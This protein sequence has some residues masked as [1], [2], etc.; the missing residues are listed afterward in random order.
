MIRTLFLFGTRP[1]AIKLAPLILE[2]R[3]R[4]ERFR[5]R[6]CVTAQHRFLLD[7]VLQTFRIVPDTDLDLMTEGQQLEDLTA[8]ALKG[9]SEVVKAEAP[10]LVLVQ[11]DTT[12]TM[13]GALAAFYQKVPVGHVEAG[14]RTDNRY[15]PFPEEVNRRITTV[16]SSLHFAPTERARDNLLRE[17]VAAAD[18]FVTG[19]TAI[20]A[21]LHVAERDAGGP[22]PDVPDLVEDRPLVLVTAHR[23]E[24]HGPPLS[25]I[26]AAVRHLAIRNPGA[27]FVVPVHPNPRVRGVMSEALSGLPNLHVVPPLPYES[28]VRL[29]KR[30]RVLLTDSGGLQEEGP[31]LGKPVLVMREETE[32]P[33][34]RSPT[35]PTSSRTG[36]WC[37]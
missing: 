10:D 24:S 17:G 11:G 12:T 32:R 30:A 4:S 29:M 5:V 35:S 22:I 9:L 16:V 33:E 15:R 21:L 19:N 27:G 6:C 8:K 36:P 31:G 13:V 28:F 23:R 7:Q 20:D 25:R 26:C 34:A 18:V 3:R 2:M 1:E 14:L 37:W